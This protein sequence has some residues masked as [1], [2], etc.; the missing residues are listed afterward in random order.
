MS[1]YDPPSDDRNMLFGMLAHQMD[2]IN[3]K[4]LGEAMKA[5]GEQR[6]KALGEVLVEQ[7]VLAPEHQ[8]LIENLVEEH[9]KL[10]GEDPQ[11]SIAALEE[12][13]RCAPSAGQL[14]V[15]DHIEYFGDYE[16][17]DVLG[18]GG[19]GVV[20]QARQVSLDRIVAV[21]MILAGQLSSES[22]VARFHAEAEAAAKLDHPGIVP[23]HEIGEYAGRHFFSMGYVEGTSLAA[24]LR[25]GLLPAKEAALLVRRIA[26]AVQH[27]HDRG[28]IHRDLKPANVLLDKEEQ[29]RLTDFGLAKRLGGDSELTVSGQVVGTPNYMSPEQAAGKIAELG[30]PTD[31]YALG[32]ILYH[33]LTGRPPFL[34]GVI[35]DTLM[36]VINQEPL[37]PTKLNS[38]CPRD[39]NT[40]CLKCLRKEPERRYASARELADDLNRWLNHEPIHARPVSFREK[41]WLCC[42]RRPAVAA[43][44]LAMLLLIVIGA[45]IGYEI[46]Q[47]GR[48]EALLGRLLDA[49]TTEVPAIVRK[50]AGYRHRVMPLLRQAN[51]DPAIHDSRRKLHLSLA[52]LSFD[53]EQVPYLADCLLSATPDEL[54]VIGNALTPHKDQLL[55]QFWGALE[56]SPDKKQTL[57]LASALAFFDPGSDRWD[58][59]AAYVVNKL[60]S[61]NPMFLGQRMEALRPAHE[62]LIAPLARIHGNWKGSRSEFERRLAAN[63]LADYAT[64][65]PQVL[66]DL[67]MD[68]QHKQFRVLLEKLS[69]HRDEAIG[70]L[71]AELDR[72]PGPQDSEDDKERLAK[73]QCNAAV[74]LLRLGQTNKLWPLLKQRADPRVR[75]W[76]IHRLSLLGADPKQ[77]AAQLDEEPDVSVRRALILS[78]GEYDHISP[79]DRHALASKLLGLYRD[80]PDPGIHGASEWLLRHLG[81]EES[82]AN[83]DVDLATG[84]VERDRGW[85]VTSQKQTMAIMPGPVEF[86]M[87]SPDTESKCYG[88]EYL[89]DERIDRSFAMATK[90]VTVEQ[91]QQFLAE[92]PSVGHGYTQRYAPEPQCPQTSVKWYDA[93]AYCRWLSEKEGIAEEQMCYPPIA[94]IQQGMRLPEDF[95]SRT[96]YRLPSEAEWEYS[97]RAGTVTSRYYGQTEELLGK[98][99]WHIFTADDRS[100]PVARLKPNDFGLF[101]M[102][103]NVREW[104]QER[105]RSYIAQSEGKSRQG[106]GDVAAVADMSSRILR[107]GSFVNRPSYIRSAIRYGNQPTY[108]AANFGFRFARTISPRLIPGTCP[109]AA[110]PSEKEDSNRHRDIAR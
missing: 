66:A 21:K 55:E 39:L 2:F 24:K 31:I 22:E 70:L 44:T 54:S 14:A 52:M 19:M 36:Q 60:V 29:P 20:Y 3:G 15:G 35:A 61:A 69:T 98:Y 92:T 110:T 33:L 84:K 88:D 89:H 94:E 13:R 79:A 4:Q 51:A 81:K 1:A 49:K 38:S 59:V 25:E 99:A 43:M 91:F 10:H 56:S 67:L 85:Y 103:G 12:I 71:Q 40:I 9:L 58:G 48:A 100:W 23:I 7:G 101:D 108:R 62:H 57:R 102:Q 107:G 73:R 77:L 109:V 45:F 26:E 74:G 32:A 27:A 8:A 47:Q 63:V 95:W 83:I 30:P 80:D 87:G 68:A 96:G 5:R 93:A 78:L 41:A 16:L 11:K 46:R 50:M 18:R 28:I 104:C 75:T 86:L 53:T 90:E 6:G 17:L 106:K 37:A 65:H 72:E 97:C 42:K 34:S 105:Y 82:I 76:L 64:D